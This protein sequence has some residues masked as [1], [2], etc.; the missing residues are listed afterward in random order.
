MRNTQISDIVKIMD[1]NELK[2]YPNNPRKNEHAIEPVANSI[3]EFGFKQPIVVDKNNTI[4]AGH[5]RLLAAK[6]L[7]LT[8]VPV[9]VADDLTPEQ[10]KAYR[11]ADN[12]TGELAGW[13]F[14]QLDLELEELDL[15]EIDMAIFGFDPKLDDGT[16]FFERENRDGAARQEGNDEYNEFLDK[17]ETKKTTDDCYTPDLVYDTVAD[18][19]AKEYGLDRADFVRPFYPGGDYVKYRYAPQAV[20]VD[21][22]PFSILAEIVRFYCERQI[23]FFLFAPSQTLF[24][25]LSKEV[26]RIGIDADVTYENN[27]CVNTSFLT[28]L[29]SGGVRSAPSLMEAVDSANLE[30]LGLSKVG[31]QRHKY[32]PHVMTSMQLAKFSKYGIEFRAGLAEIAFIRELDQQKD[33]NSSIFG[34]GFLLSESKTAEKVAAEAKIVATRDAMEEAN[35]KRWE[36]SDREWGI[37]RSLG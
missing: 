13:D 14:E 1:I 29:E 7:G 22:P 10:V 32:P 24:S 21:N 23:R 12:K 5:T 6:E 11:L 33:T 4:I 9:I 20:V 37:I 34:G 19:V 8:E 16:S 36:L 25:V 31:R 28:N 35:T 15:P 18:W 17:F 3:R 26:C 2:P 30:N 27:A